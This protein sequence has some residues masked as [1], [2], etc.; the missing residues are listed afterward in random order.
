MKPNLQ[1][2]ADNIANVIPQDEK[3]ISPAEACAILLD[4]VPTFV[5]KLKKNM[6]VGTEPEKPTFCITAYDYGGNSVQD[7]FNPIDTSMV[8]FR[9][10]S[11]SYQKAS[12]TISEIRLALQS[13]PG[14]EFRG[15]VIIGIWVESQIDL[16]AKSP[17]GFS[18][19]TI[20]LRL[21]TT[22]KDFGHRTF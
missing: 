19:F 6:F 4:A 11:E 21:A 16:T 9:V 18:L 14:A 17:Q 10:R 2:A 7:S 13:L 12:Q 8:Q 20:N 1:E 5:G 3:I 22:T 15:I